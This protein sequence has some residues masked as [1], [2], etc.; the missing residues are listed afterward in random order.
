ML[1]FQRQG[2]DNVFLYPL[3]TATGTLVATKAVLTALAI[4]T[5]AVIDSL[6]L[7]GIYV[8]MAIGLSLSFGVTRLINFAHGEVVMLG[9]Y[10]AF[11][12]FTLLHIDPLVA[13]LPVAAFEGLTGRAAVPHGSCPRNCGAPRQPD[14]VD[15][16]L[17][18]GSAKPR[19]AA[20]DRQR[21]RRRSRLRFP[22]ARYSAPGSWCRSP[23][24]W[25]SAW[26]HCW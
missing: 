17:G 19:A 11:W 22:V 3:A 13:L 16:R 15:L 10:G 5:Q 18:P 26:P 20:V 21:A 12:L 8:L 7:G 24:W 2:G 6:L 9:G 25:R 14:P 4:F 23:R 1:V